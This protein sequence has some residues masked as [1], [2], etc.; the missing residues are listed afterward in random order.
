M[1][2]TERKKVLI[3]KIKHSDQN[4]FERIEAL[5]EDEGALDASLDRAKMQVATG[6]TIPHG[7]VRKKYE[8][9]LSK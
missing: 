1:T 2:I 3:E 7:E 6:Q 5:L 9:W 4:E 8:K